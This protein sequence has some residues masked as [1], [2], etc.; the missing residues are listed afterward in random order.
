MGGLVAV[1]ALVKSLSYSESQVR[2][3][4][5]WALGKI[6]GKTARDALAQ[7]LNSAIDS[8]VHEEIKVALQKCSKVT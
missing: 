2:L 8:E 7:S 3:Y 6:G 4:V 5:A 1:P